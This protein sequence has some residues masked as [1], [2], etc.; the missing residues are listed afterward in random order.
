VPAAFACSAGCTPVTAGCYLH[1]KSSFCLHRFLHQMFAVP[2]QA[3]SHHAACLML[4][5]CCFYMPL[6]GYCVC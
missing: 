4:E 2:L 1:E 5:W 3:N 6:T